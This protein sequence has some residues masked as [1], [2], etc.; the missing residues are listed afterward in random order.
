MAKSITIV[1]L[2]P[3]MTKFWTLAAY[4]HLTEA[5]TVYVQTKYHPSVT[6]IPG[7]V[8]SFQGWY[9]TT[10]KLEAIHDRLAVE[11]VRLGQQEE[12]VTYAVPGHP[13]FDETVPRI[14]TLAKQQQIPVTI[15]AGLSFIEPAITA[16]QPINVD[17]LQLLRAEQI[18][19]QYYSPPINPDKPALIGPMYD[20]ETIRLWQ[21]VLLNL[22]QPDYRVTLVQAAGQT[23]ERVWSCRL[24][25]L[26]EP[27]AWDN[28][29]G[30]MLYL[31]ADEQNCSFITF[32][33]TMAQL[34]SPDGC[35]WDRKQTH[36]SLRP[37][38]LEECYEV[39]ET[40]DHDD[41]PALV[42][43]LGDLLLQ[44]ALHTQIATRDGNFQW[45]DV[46]GHINRK[47]IRRHPHVFANVVVD[48]AGEILVNWEAIKKSEK[49]EK[50]QSLVES[51]SALDGILEGLPALAQ[52]LAISK[53]AV[54]AGFEWD[55][56][57][58]VLEKVIEEAGEIAHATDAANLEAEIGDLLFSVVNLA[59]WHNID[60][61]SALRTMNARF[62][63]RFKR[64]E[65]LAVAQDQR[66][67]DMP[68][69]DM[70]A[71]WQKAKRQL[72]ESG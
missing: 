32:Q 66:L 15:I 8:N 11:I 23:D 6:D 57:D 42:E 40:L 46:L 71:L 28:K 54:R 13:D 7:Q 55:D 3:G 60:A 5:T 36:Q 1:G 4:Q 48:G 17:D 65:Q 50:G 70:E 72:A 37:Y 62:T 19:S 61:E 51:T 39:L 24:V 27:L 12:G 52:A 53:K 59:R 43:E 18:T 34:L 26:A 16:L 20:A 14:Y 9:E 63:R 25:E 10:A 68:L 31:P 2:G 21:P 69:S 33:Q 29:T 58:G 47:M 30:I 64:M 56:I 22:Y 41:L 38:L 44:I 67:A 49:A 35:P 45:G